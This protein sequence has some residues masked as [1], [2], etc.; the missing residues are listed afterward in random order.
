MAGVDALHWL[1]MTRHGE[2]TGNLA[3]QAVAGTDAEEVGIPERDADIPLSDTG[4]AQA[5][6]FG[7]WLAALPEDE[8]PTLVVSSPYVRA[9]DTAKIALA[10]TSYAAPRDPEGLRPKVDERLRDREQGVLQGLTGAGVER[11]FP[12][13]AE[14]LRHLGK[15]YYRPPGGESW[16][17][18]ALRLR[19]FYRDLAA[20]APG[21]RV[22]VVAHDAIVVMTRYLVEELTEQEIMEIEKE[23]IANASVTRWRRNGASLRAVSYNDRTHLV[24]EGA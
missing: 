9:L 13:E 23:S 2:S 4:R 15:F 12:E 7:R 11:R 22:L 17:D 16:A 21:G 24:D 10:Q 5:A 6:S 1:T 3:Y 14:R 18:L 19:S 8:R 20:A